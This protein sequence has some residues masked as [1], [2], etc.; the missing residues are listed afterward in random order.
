[1][2]VLPIS[3]IEAEEAAENL[4]D[5]VEL[6]KPITWYEFGKIT[7]MLVDG[8]PEPDTMD[9]KNWV[10]W[11]SALRKIINQKIRDNLK[12]PYRLF[13]EQH[14]VNLVLQRDEQMA[15][16]LQIMETDKIGRTLKT[17]ARRLR[18]ISLTLESSS[19]AT[20]MLLSSAKHSEIS[21][22][23]T[24]EY[25]ELARTEMREAM[26]EKKKAEEQPPEQKKGTPGE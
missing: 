21:L 24:A 25:A 6:N 18:Q 16:R 19:P 14:G 5:T 26:K 2:N 11:R 3:Q 9:Y 15:E 23:I 7:G 10:A 17:A 20:A 13:L 8:E 12:K 1:M 22:K 4:L